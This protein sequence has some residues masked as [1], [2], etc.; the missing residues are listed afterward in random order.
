MGTIAT[1]T[2]TI[3]TV[4][5]VQA[6]V[7]PA[8]W[9]HQLR[10]LQ[11]LR[12]K[13]LLPLLLGPIA[14]RVRQGWMRTTST[15][16]RTPS[17]RCCT[18]AARA[19][20]AMAAAARVLATPLVCWAAEAHGDAATTHIRRC[21]HCNRCCLRAVCGELNALGLWRLLICSCHFYR[22]FTH[23]ADL[24]EIVRDLQSRADHFE[25]TKPKVR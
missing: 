22:H 25:A 8:K 4:L 10:C 19:V 24:L 23:R 17:W 13:L 15:C 3:P 7:V 2:M 21:Q 5:S 12:L 6:V 20:V 9:Q 14:P 18:M 16:R 11:R 1:E